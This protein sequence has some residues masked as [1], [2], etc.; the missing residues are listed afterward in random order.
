M[1][2]GGMAARE[3]EVDPSIYIHTHT[4]KIVSSR[5]VTKFEL[6]HS[7]GTE[8]IVRECRARMSNNLR[9]VRLSLPIAVK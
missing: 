6:R 1:S 2:Y 4:H 5:C 9:V 3:P 7:N 8:Q